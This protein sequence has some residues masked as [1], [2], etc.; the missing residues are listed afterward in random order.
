MPSKRENQEVIIQKLEKIEEEITE[1]KK[2]VDKINQDRKTIKKAFTVQ[3]LCRLFSPCLKCCTG[4]D[5][6]NDVVDVVLETVE[7]N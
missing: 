3:R 1:L 7:E 4:V 6:P 5:V 2:V